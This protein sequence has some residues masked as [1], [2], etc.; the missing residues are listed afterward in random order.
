MT[1]RN[2]KSPDAGFYAPVTKASIPIRKK[3][4]RSQDA[5][6]KDLLETL[7]ENVRHM[8]YK[9]CKPAQPR[10]TGVT[11]P[12]LLHINHESR[13]NSLR[14]YTVIFTDPIRGQPV[15]FD[16]RRDV[17]EIQGMEAAF[18]LLGKVLSFTSKLYEFAKGGEMT[19]AM[20]K[21]RNLSVTSGARPDRLLMEHFSGLK[22]STD[23]KYLRTSRIGASFTW[24][25][26]LRNS[27]LQKHQ[28][29][30]DEPDFSQAMEDFKSY[31]ASFSDYGGDNSVHKGV[32]LK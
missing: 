20:M 11:V 32:S 27:F 31:A 21:V 5:P 30:S 24:A 6:S 16:L 18:V 12:V 13:A 3:R 1:H 9:L 19:T 26:S 23:T 15:S 14:F 2:P 4:R 28:K 29:F 25:K 7:P 17:L 22:E 8:I 10:Y